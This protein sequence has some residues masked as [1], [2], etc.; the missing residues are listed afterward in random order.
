[1]GETDTGFVRLGAV[2][3]K[4]LAGN[5]TPALLEGL[6]AARRGEEVPAVEQAACGRCRD[7]G[8]LR[9]NVL[10]GEPGFGEPV[11]CSCE[12]GRQR[13]RRRQERIFGETGVPQRFRKYTVA[14]LDKRYPELAAK[15]RAWQQT[16]RWLLLFGPKGTCKTGASAVLA[17]DYLA[18]H[19]EGAVLFMQPADFLDRVRET[20]GNDSDGPTARQV[21][22]SLVDVPLL[23]LDDVG[24]G[25]LSAWAQEQ[26]YR[27]INKRWEMGTARQTI[28]NTNLPLH[29][30]ATY[31]DPEGR[32]LDRIKDWAAV[33]ETS[34]PSRRGQGE[35]PF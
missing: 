30:L 18:A 25:T 27:A 16:D 35:L 22:E 32:S 15:L 4:I 23:V 26:L 13:E 11:D 6:E 5:A 17:L 34:G 24:V 3:E 10:P 14:T 9:R 28:V 1:M 12:V 31:L 7:I 19:G 20:Y 21:L 2:V 8:Y 29:R 33:I